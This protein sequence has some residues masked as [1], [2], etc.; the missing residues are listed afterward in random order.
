MNYNY[1]R[2][3]DPQVGRYSESDPIGLQGG[4]STYGYA[5]QSPIRHSDRTGLAIFICNRGAWGG[6]GG[7]A[8]HAYLW[9]SSG[10]RCCGM[11][12]PH[13][14][15]TSCNEKGPD[16]GDSCTLIAG[17]DGK[18]A[19]IFSCCKRTANTGWWP[20][21]DCQDLANDCISKAGLVSPGAPGGRFGIC[22]SCSKKPLGSSPYPF[23]PD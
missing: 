6:T 2:D 11:A 9:D 22:D 17:S 23:N 4:L 1:F 10:R 7:L 18:E 5:M 13:N 19:E 20:K 21:Y 15:I 8:N 14:P 3:Y 16:G 12:R